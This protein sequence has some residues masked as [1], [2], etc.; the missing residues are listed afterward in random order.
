MMP[1]LNRIFVTH[2]TADESDAGSDADFQLRIRMP[3]D[4]VIR[5][6]PDLPHDERE[7]GR[8]DFY[9]F[10][11]SGDNV[12]SDD[13]VFRITMKMINTDDGWLPQSIFVIGETT[14]GGIVTLG[15]HPQWSD[16]WFDRGSD[17]AGPEEHVISS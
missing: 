7:R 14:T 3:G 5:D 16:G 13:P 10:D 2:T 1:Q 4:D 15:A 12:N 6:F 8:T 9:E 17:A 11:V